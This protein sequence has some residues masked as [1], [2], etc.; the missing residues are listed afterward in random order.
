MKNKLEATP[1][2][3]EQLVQLK[4]LE[5][6]HKEPKPPSFSD[7]W[8]KADRAVDEL[9]DTY[10]DEYWERAKKSMRIPISI[11]RKRA[12]FKKFMA[13]LD[14]KGIILEGS[15]RT[16]NPEIPFNKEAEAAYKKF[17]KEQFEI[18]C[19]KIEGA[20]LNRDLAEFAS[21]P[22]LRT[23]TAK[24]LMPWL[25]EAAKTGGSRGHPRCRQV[26]GNHASFGLVLRP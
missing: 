1:G 12:E 11:P 6:K 16:R 26:R 19:L 9:I 15:G 23:K 3:F 18:R 8:S 13:V 7:L 14:S 20:K 25:V 24:K 22:P 17:R 2:Q 21:L 5:Q 10:P 4:L